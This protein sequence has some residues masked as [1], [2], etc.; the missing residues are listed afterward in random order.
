MSLNRIEY[1]RER[2]N[3]LDES[4]LELLVR[5]FG[6][7]REISKEKR[8]RGENF[9][10][11]EREE[12]E[13]IV[14]L[15]E[16]VPRYVNTDMLTRLWGSI[17][18]VTRE[19]QRENVINIPMR[20]RGDELDFYTDVSDRRAVIF[21]NNGIEDNSRELFMNGILGGQLAFDVSEQ[22][23]MRAFEDQRAVH[24]RVGFH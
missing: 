14:R 4:I 11:G 18:S 23:A 13:T 3:A 12:Y 7:E 21:M 24:A 20:V 6:Y 9:E 1:Y 17:Y 10:S 19:L 5:R 16:L 15:R 8:R 2:V 22:N